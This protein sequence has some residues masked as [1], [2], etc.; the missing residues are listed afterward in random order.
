MAAELTKID[1]DHAKIYQKNL[2]E[3]KGKIATL[4]KKVFREMQNAAISGHVLFTQDY[5][6]FEDYFAFKP[7]KVVLTGHGHDLRMSDI[8]EF[9]LL[10]GEGKVTCVL[11]DRY[12]ESNAVQ[13]L[14]RNHHLNY[15]ALDLIGNPRRSESDYFQ[16]ME[17]ISSQIASC[18]Q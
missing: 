11:G 2:S 3:F 14:A 17:D 8:R 6:Y 7:L 9:D 18:S 15:V 12:D 4:E 5:Q 1:P 10:V 16:I 13:K